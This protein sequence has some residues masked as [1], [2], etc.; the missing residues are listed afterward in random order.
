[1]TFP[2]E[3]KFLLRS[4][5]GWVAIV[6]ILSALIFSVGLKTQTLFGVEIPV[7]EITEHS[8]ASAIFERMAQDLVPPGIE[9]AATSPLDAF[10]IEIELSVLLALLLISPF[11]LFA[12]LRYLSPALYEREKR[13]LRLAVVPVFVLFIAGAAFAYAFV[14]PKTFAFLYIYVPALGVMP[15]FFVREFI[16]EVVAFLVAAGFMFQ[17]PVAMVLLS[18]LG[19]ISP[20][21]WRTHWRYAVL[22]FLIATAII[23]PDGSGVTMLMFSLPLTLL[24]MGG[25]FL[26]G[27]PAVRSASLKV[28]SL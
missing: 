1:M 25:L 5:L 15:L 10:V 28:K 9:L 6:L 12:V 19:I 22:T 18:R 4:F 7:P 8:F 16:A 2:S 14:I 24:Y 17:V 11:L 23:T 21:F 3:F 27:R 13:V 20:L 26:S